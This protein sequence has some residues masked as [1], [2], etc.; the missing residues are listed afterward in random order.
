MSTVDAVAERSR[1]IR[2]S[3]WG[4]GFRFVQ[5]RNLAFWVYVVV[6]G[7]GVLIMSRYIT[8]GTNRYGSVISASVIMFALYGALFWWF[9][10]R[11]DRYA[12]Q[13]AKLIVTAFVWGAFGAITMASFA[14]TPILSLWSKAISQRWSLDWG[15]GLTAP[16]TE[17]FAKGLGLLLLIALAPRLIATAFDGFILGAFIGLGFQLMEDITY[18]VGAAGSNFG[19]DPLPSVFQVVLMRMVTGIA[20]HILFSSIFCAGLVYLVGRPAQQRRRGR[21]IAL[22]LTAMALHGVWDDNSGIFGRIDPRLPFLMMIV[23]LV[24][25]VL[26][27]I[28]V[29]DLTVPP[30]RE[31][32]RAM[33]APEV[34]AGTVTEEERDTLA[35]NR[36]ARKAYA[37]TGDKR[38]RRYLLA[39]VDDLAD[40]LARSGGAETGRVAFARSEVRRLRAVQK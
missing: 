7:Y 26:I 29:F 13:S 11:I 21:G 19:A 37:R 2:Q 31:F 40:E 32:M 18:A 38:H 25:A 5:P 28:R 6:V 1:I 24:I 17:E 22:M 33:L 15:A 36:K 34:A 10:H 20:G 39:A 4:A 3:G 8:A 23:L 14:N 9:T 35:G 30:E 27:V 16:F 12:G